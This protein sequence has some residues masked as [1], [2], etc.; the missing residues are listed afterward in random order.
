M[1]VC[2]PRFHVRG[3]QLRSEY[4]LRMRIANREETYCKCNRWSLGVHH[5][6]PEELYCGLNLSVCTMKWEDGKSCH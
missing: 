1:F 4:K 5:Y 2:N 6:M 3:C